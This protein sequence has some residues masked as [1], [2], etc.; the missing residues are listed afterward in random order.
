MS[1]SFFFFFFNPLVHVYYVL[2]GYP[3][4]LSL[5]F[6]SPYTCILNLEQVEQ[7]GYM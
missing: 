1:L 2:T 5:F 6:K 4:H 3:K 7:D